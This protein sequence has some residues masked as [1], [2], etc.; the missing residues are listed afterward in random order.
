MESGTPAQILQQLIEQKMENAAG[1]N[2]LVVMRHEIKY[3]LEGIEKSHLSTL[4]AER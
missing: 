3:Q 1:D 2:D 4:G